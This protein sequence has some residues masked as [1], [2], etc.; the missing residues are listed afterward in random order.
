VLLRDLPDHGGGA[1][2]EPILGSVAGLPGIRV[3]LGGGGGLCGW[4]GGGTRLD[5]GLGLGLRGS[6]LRRGCLLGRLG[7]GRG[8]A[9]SLRV[10]KGHNGADLHRL[11]FLHQDLHQDSLRRGGDFRIH[12]V[13]GDLQQGLISLDG[14][15]HLLEPS[16]YG[17]LGDG[18]THLGHRDF[19]PC[20]PC[21]SL[22]RFSSD[23]SDSQLT[24]PCDSLRSYKAA[25]RTFK[26]GSDAVGPDRRESRWEAGFRHPGSR[27][28]ARRGAAY[29]AVPEGWVQGPVRSAADRPE[30]WT[31]AAGP[32]KRGSTGPG[33]IP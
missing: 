20:H 7:R 19:D 11:P 1:G 16:R 3:R 28:P 9:G 10:H 8:S 13:G 4:R 17:A 27:L 29:R 21:A 32:G 2:A 31:W 14:L 25:S 24:K 6:R 15:T 23:H 33:P 22:V 18:F 26:P 12:F 5:V 30:G